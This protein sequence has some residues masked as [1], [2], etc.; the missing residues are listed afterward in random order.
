LKSILFYFIYL[1]PTQAVCG[2]A[3]DMIRA[4]TLVFVMNLASASPAGTQ[5]GPKYML[6]DSRNV[7]ST[8]AAL[9]LGAVEKHGALIKEERDYEMRFDNMQPSVWYDPQMSKWRAWY[10][11]FTNCSKAKDK[12]PMCNNA[13]QKCGSVSPTTSYSQA[14]RGEG[15]LY[16][17]SDD[18]I[19]WTKPNLGMTNWK[20]SKDNNLIELDGMTTQI[21]LDESAPPSERYKVVTGSN[22]AG[23][24]AVS[25]DGITWKETKNLQP[26]HA[27][28]DTPKNLVWDAD[29]R[30]WII[31]VRSTPTVKYPVG[32]TLRIQSYV[33]SLTEDF[34]GNW[35]TTMTT[36]LNTSAQYQP[37]GLVVFPYEGIYVGIG[38]VFNPSQE[39]GPAA[40]IGQVCKSYSAGCTHTGCTHW[41][42]THVG[43]FA[44]FSPIPSPRS[45]WCSHGAQMV[46][47]GTGSNRPRASSPLARRASSTRVGCSVRSKIQS[48]Q[49][50]TTRYYIQCALYSL[51]SLC[52]D[53]G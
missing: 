26:T 15:F 33:H 29:R 39:D 45:T 28:W 12:V 14:G 11:S 34:M 44:P 37:D 3:I 24:I 5:A 13:P 35:S 38:N 19:E 8:D 2:G 48:G 49:W 41:L 1:D 4:I 21:Y 53:N 17:E 22:G 23:S 40:P 43:A 20:G 6:L 42:H 30:Q 18:G 31:Y 25:A 36:G 50:L 47:T 52:P 51:Y 27:R 9:V 16:A 32:G 10:S 7:H 46:G